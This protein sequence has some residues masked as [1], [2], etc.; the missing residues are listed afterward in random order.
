MKPLEQRVY[1]GDLAN[2]V[3]ENPVFQS[4]FD[5]IEKEL[6]EAW[7]SSPNRDVEGRERVFLMMAM[8]GKIKSCLLT[9]M[10]TGKLAKEEL[11]HK[12]TMR[13]RL[14]DWLG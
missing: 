7:K 10:E 6:T 11:R 5:D 12:Q 3:L 8:L 9:T 2:T 14:N 1:D 4:V 13:D